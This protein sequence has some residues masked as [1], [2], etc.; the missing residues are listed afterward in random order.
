MPAM[1]SHLFHNP[2]NPSQLIDSPWG[3]IESWRASALATGEMSGY[4][5]YMKQVRS[6]ATLVHDAINAREDAVSQREQAIAAREA[7][8][9]DA[10]TKMHALL[11]RCD[12]IVKAEEE[13]REQQREGP[14]PSPT[15]NDEGDLEPKLAK[16][17]DLDGDLKNPE[18]SMLTLP[19]KDEYETEF[20]QPGDP[21][22]PEP[23][24]QRAPAA[25]E[26][27]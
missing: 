15:A 3:K 25:F 11:G 18:H 6:D 16:S 13:R 24:L 8:V 14:L 22:L 19:R 10:I 9:R 21:D 2:E 27:N 4:A 26:D 23:D 5:D 12:A 7:F 1:S 17:E 20:P